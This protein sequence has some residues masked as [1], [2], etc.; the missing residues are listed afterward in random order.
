MADG[1]IA[2]GLTVTIGTEAA[3]LLLTEATGESRYRRFLEDGCRIGDDIRSYHRASK[4]LG[5]KH[6]YTWLARAHAQVCYYDMVRRTDPCD[7]APYLAAAD[8]AISRAC[9][10]Y[11][12]ISGSMTGT[13][14]WGECW[15]ASQIGLG[16]WGET[17]ASAYLM[18]LSA[19]LMELRGDSLYGDIFERVLYNAFFSAQ[20]PDGLKYRYWTPF[21]ETPPWFDRD[22]FCCPNNYK[23]EIFEVP[24]AV[25]YRTRD[26]VA[27]N[28]FAPAKLASGSVTAEM[29]TD[30]PLDGRVSID[31]T[32][33][34]GMSL[35][36][37]RV[38][39]WCGNLKVDRCAVTDRNWHV[40]TGDFSS[41]R[42]VEIEMEMPIR[43]VAGRQAQEGRVAVMRGPCVYALNCVTNGLTDMDWAYVYDLDL[44]KPM[45]WR[46]GA[47]SA[48]LIA[49]NPESSSKA[50]TLTRYWDPG[51]TRTYFN[52]VGS[53]KTVSDELKCRGSKSV[54]HE[55]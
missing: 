17:C 1:F 20:S 24:D 10:P 12:S 30:Y 11:M 38:P 55:W 18:R 2:N 21:D 32:M 25:F 41:G 28:L 54:W 51:R 42:S 5:V 49:G 19:K 22:T 47:I 14:S 26:G 15:D 34:K 39:S 50:V 7:D 43:L 13:R 46:D 3:F 48:S 4:Q 36:W 6:V 31:V 9:G 23:R 33:P 16:K 53:M 52:Y 40:V 35:L 45:E 44:T 37:I 29:R 8:E 27:V